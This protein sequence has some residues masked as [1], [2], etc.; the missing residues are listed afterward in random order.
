M[1]K[2]LLSWIF[3]PYSLILESFGF[4]KDYNVSVY[5]AVLGIRSTGK[6]TLQNYFRN[7]KGPTYSTQYGGEDQEEIVI[8]KGTKKVRIK[9]GKDISGGKESLRDFSEDEIG[10]SNIIFF[11]YDASRFCKESEYQKEVSAFLIVV[12]RIN[13]GKRPIHLI[14]T[15]IDKIVI[16]LLNEI[17]SE[18]IKYL[19]SV[20]IQRGT[21]LEISCKSISFIDLTNPTD[22]NSLKDKLFN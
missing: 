17:K 6:T 10:K 12:C 20:F 19:N 11:L 7:I 21:T 1:K 18:I 9:K 15:H 2:K 4:W 14:G 13:R 22:L 16:N 5:I 3:F 8:V